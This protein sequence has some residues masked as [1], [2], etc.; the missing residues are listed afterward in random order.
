M[1]TS[2]K[3]DHEDV[4]KKSWIFVEI[5]RAKSYPKHPLI[6][7]DAKEQ[8]MRPSRCHL[9]ARPLPIIE[10]FPYLLLFTTLLLGVSAYAEPR[11]PKEGFSAWVETVKKDAKKFGIG[12]QTIRK[13]DS[14]N[15]V[16][17]VVSLDNNQPF[18][19]RSF[20]WY[21][22][23]I[24]PKSRIEKGRKLLKKHHKILQKIS[25]KYGV[26]PRFIVALWGIESNFG[27]NMG[28][29]SIPDALATLAYDGRRREFFTK[30][31]LHA[32]SIID[33]GHADFNSMKGS[34]AGAMGQTQFMPS[35]FTELAVDYDK[36]G[37]RDIWNTQS[38]VFAS[39]AHYLSKRGWDPE[40]TWGRRVQTPTS[41]KSSWFGRRTQKTL[42]E[43]D[44][45]GVTSYNGRRLPLSRGTLPA[46]LIQ[47]DDNDASDQYLVYDNYNTLLKW[48]RSLY[49]ATAV[50]LLSDGIGGRTN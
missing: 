49:F 13:L 40:T 28:N 3:I 4:I 10:L 21:K 38:D 5:T 36:D 17:K 6:L 31:L 25:Q 33:Q 29:Y 26:Q 39:I 14:L 50:G 2:S 19:T 30:E 42:K 18:K 34:W 8:V 22:E 46:S 44:Q 48:N 24:V 1:G 27:T 12:D 47:P 45:L 16:D 9:F 20:A 15:Y 11:N 37:K 41:T 43:W 32:L 7:T 23:N 35:S